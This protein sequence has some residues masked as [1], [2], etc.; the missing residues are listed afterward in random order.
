MMSVEVLGQMIDK[1]GYQVM[2][3]GPVEELNYDYNTVTQVNY[4]IDTNL[5]IN[6]YFSLMSDKAA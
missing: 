1:L 2:S 5:P 3:I 6:I 4:V